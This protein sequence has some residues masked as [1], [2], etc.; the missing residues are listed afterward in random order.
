MAILYFTLTYWGGE[1][2]A[3]SQIQR[4]WKTFMV[5]EQMQIIMSMQNKFSIR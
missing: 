5:A 3:I 2:N 4:R 1:A